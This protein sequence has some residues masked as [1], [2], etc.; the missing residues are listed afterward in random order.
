MM[1]VAV[2]GAHGHGRRRLCLSKVIASQL[3]PKGRPC[4]LPDAHILGLKARRSRVDPVVRKFGLDCWP[5][6]ASKLLLLIA[7]EEL[8]KAVAQK[9]LLK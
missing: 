8:G 5:V 9:V 6:R 2:A 7:L 4:E 3:R 1:Q